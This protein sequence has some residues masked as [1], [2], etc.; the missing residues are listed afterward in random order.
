MSFENPYQSPNQTTVANLAPWDDRRFY[1]YPTWRCW[2]LAAFVLPGLATLWLTAR[3]AAARQ[4]DFA[5]ILF[6]SFALVAAIILVTSL[7]VIFL[8]WPTPRTQSVSPMLRPQMG[9][10]LVAIIILT[11]ES[12]LSLLISTIALV[13]ITKERKLNFVARDNFYGVLAMFLG[14]F[15]GALAIP[16][17]IWLAADFLGKTRKFLSMWFFVA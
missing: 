7:T 12:L 9:A 5:A 1:S 16:L 14:A 2:L 10:C 15:T 13:H 11:S 3:N 8:L 4:D 6:N 17:G